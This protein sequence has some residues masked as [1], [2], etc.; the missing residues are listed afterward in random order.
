M[1]AG[2]SFPGDGVQLT[3]IEIDSIY[4]SVAGV[5][6][7]K[8]GDKIGEEGAF[9]QVVEKKFNLPPGAFQGLLASAVPKSPREEAVPPEAPS[10]ALVEVRGVGREL[11]NWGNCLQ[12]GRTC[13]DFF[14]YNRH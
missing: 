10:M 7:E 3:D 13:S 11:L 12:L 2:A 5:V 9:I 6:K 14:A 4:E 8:V 1:G